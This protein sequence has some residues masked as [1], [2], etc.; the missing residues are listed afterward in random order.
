MI[1]YSYV[2]LPEASQCLAAQ[3]RMQTSLSR[4]ED[5][6][7]IS[8]T[9]TTLRSPAMHSKKQAA[10]PMVNTD[11]CPLRARPVPLQPKLVDKVPPGV[12]AALEKTA[13]R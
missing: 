9:A 6:L 10:E 5:R 7:I 1:F 2:G 8:E 12:E 13:T 4:S 3:D 11:G